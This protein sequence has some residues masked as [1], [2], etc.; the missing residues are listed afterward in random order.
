MG[1]AGTKSKPINPTTNETIP[2]GF[3]KIGQ[4]NDAKE[5][6]SV[7]SKEKTEKNEAPVERQG[8]TQDN[9]VDSQP[10]VNT[11]TP[12]DLIDEIFPENPF[13]KDDLR[14]YYDF[15]STREGLDQEFNKG[16]YGQNPF[17]D[18][19]EVAA[20]TKY[21]GQWTGMAIT[22]FGKLTVG[23]DRIV[24]TG[25]FEN[26]KFSG[27]GVSIMGDGSKVKGSFKA[28]AADGYCV[29]EWANGEKHFGFW[30]ENKR[31]GWGKMIMEGGHVAYNNYVNGVREGIGRAFFADGDTYTGEFKQNDISG[32][33]VYTWADGRYYKGDFEL[34]EQHGYGMM[35]WPSG[36]VYEGQFTKGKIEGIG[37]MK[38]TDGTMYYGEMKNGKP[39]GNGT[40]YDTE[41]NYREGSWIEGTRSLWKGELTVVKEYPESKSAISLVPPEMKELE[42]DPATIQS[43]L[44]DFLIRHASC[45]NGLKEWIGMKAIQLGE[46]TTSPQISLKQN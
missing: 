39:H 44:D 45:D 32:K 15:P 38:N 37:M 34:S 43:N 12:Q 2:E 20:D 40:H 21:T 30:E 28:G 9:E 8:E 35:T 29:Y 24:Y 1:C 7:M 17:V 18:E 25:D 42:Y 22:G 36:K 19:T 11:K 31:K 4:V 26:N 27:L 41:G 3:V 46:Y 5:I 16:I 6:D 13:P 10:N 33:G 23:K 14:C